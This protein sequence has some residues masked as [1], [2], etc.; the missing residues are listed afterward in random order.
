MSHQPLF[1]GAG[2]VQMLGD[3]PGG[4]DLAAQGAAGGAFVDSALT[5]F[6]RESGSLQDSLHKPQGTTGYGDVT[7]G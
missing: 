7:P 4:P 1:D 2:R 6:E 5:F 3:V